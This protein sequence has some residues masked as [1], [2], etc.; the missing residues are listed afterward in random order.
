MKKILFVFVCQFTISCASAPTVKKASVF[1]EAKKSVVKPQPPKTVPVPIVQPIPGQLR[2]NPK[3]AAP[4]AEEIANAVKNSRGKTTA[5]IID[6]ANRK[7]RSLPIEEGYYNAVQVYDYAP[8]VIYQVYT[9]PLRLTMIQL[10]ISE[11][12]ISIAAGDTIRWLIDQTTSG[13]GPTSRVMVL[14]KPVRSGHETNVI[15]TTNLR[16]YQLELHAYKKTYMAS[17]SWNYPYDM[18]TKMASKSEAKAQSEKKSEPFK[19]ST[20]IEKLNFGYQFVASKTTPP[21][22]MPI[23]VFDDGAKTYLQ[24]RAGTKKRKM[25]ALF[26]LSKSGEPQIV[27]YRVRGDY[28]VVDGLFDLAQLRLGE[29][30]PVTVGIERVKQ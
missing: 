21:R 25:P 20:S 29:K 16:V 17:V 13:V 8:G 22:W 27:N 19:V 12:V 10:G 2:P 18:A 5:A 3:L 1:V 26:L 14:I 7:A 24:F 4:K 6:E 11:E 15:I 30:S 9:A 28:Y 23:R